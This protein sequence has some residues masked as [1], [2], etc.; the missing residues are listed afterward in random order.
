[1][2]PVLYVILMLLRFILTVVFRPVYMSAGGD[3]SMRECAFVCVAG[4]RGAASLIMGS[5]VVTWQTE[6]SRGTAAETFSVRCSEGASC[7]VVTCHAV[8]GAWCGFPSLCTPLP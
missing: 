7:T 8:C 2:L 4:L 5:A 1:M 6:G 3:M